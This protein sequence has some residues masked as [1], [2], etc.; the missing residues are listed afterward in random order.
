MVNTLHFLPNRFL[1]WWGRRHRNISAIFVVI[2]YVDISVG[3][4]SFLEYVP[5]NWKI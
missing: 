1:Q 3:I 5:K 4:M 2:C